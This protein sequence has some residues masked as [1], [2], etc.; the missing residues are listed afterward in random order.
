[1]IEAWF[2]EHLRW[3]NYNVCEDI[4]I[5]GADSIRLGFVHII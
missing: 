2:I 3:E 5:D 4:G 1:V